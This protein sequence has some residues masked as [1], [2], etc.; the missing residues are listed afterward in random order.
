M[1]IPNVVKIES[2][3]KWLKPPRL[4][5]YWDDCQNEIRNSSQLVLAQFWNFTSRVTWINIENHAQACRHILSG[6][7]QFL[8]TM[9]STAAFPP[10]TVQAVHQDQIHQ[11]PQSLD[12]RVNW[13]APPNPAQHQNRCQA[14]PLAFWGDLDSNCPDRTMPMHDAAGSKEAAKDLFQAPPVLPFPTSKPCE[15]L[16]RPAQER[17]QMIRFQSKFTRGP[18]VWVVKSLLHRFSCR[19]VP[20]FW[21][22]DHSV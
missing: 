17:D 2:G 22:V 12:R 8:P 16:S 15:S 1:I 9:N 6:Y 14:L 5:E 10:H 13:K 19:F 18:I 11:I 3:W 4:R 20:W 7:Y 21:G